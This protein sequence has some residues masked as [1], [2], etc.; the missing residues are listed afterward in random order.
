MPDYIAQFIAQRRLD[1]HAQS[2]G[3]QFAHL[4]AESVQGL[5]AAVDPV[6]HE[7]HGDGAAQY[8]CQNKENPQSGGILAVFIVRDVFYDDE[9]II[10]AAHIDC[11]P[12]GAMEGGGEL[13]HC[14]APFRQRCEIQHFP[15]YGICGI[16]E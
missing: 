2:A 4:L 6:P 5:Q 8:E 10:F 3:L 9:P 7:G 13:P 11:L 14:I 16:E 12:R 15:L 1:L